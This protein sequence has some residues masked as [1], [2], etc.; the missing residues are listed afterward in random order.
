MSTTRLAE[1]ISLTRAPSS[2]FRIAIIGGVAGGAS[3]AAKARRVSELHE[4]TVFESG[5]YVS[6]ANCGLP[7]LA[8]STQ[9]DVTALLLSDP[10]R[11]R[12]RFNVEVKVNHRVIKIDRERRILHVASG[13]ADTVQHPYDRLIIATGAGAIMP[14][15]AVLPT[16]SPHNNVWAVKSIHDAQHIKE[17]T[18]S[19]KRCVIVGAGFV[20]VEMAEQLMHAGLHVTMLEMATH[21][22][23]P[24]DEDIACGTCGVGRRGHRPVLTRAAGFLTEMSDVIATS[25]VDLRLG[26]K[27]AGFVLNEAGDRVTA[28][29]IDG[30]Q[31]PLETDMVIL[32]LGV[33]SMSQLARDCGLQVGASGGIVVD[34]RMQT[35]D[36]F[37]YA[38]GDVCETTHLVSGHKMVTALAG[39]ANKQGRVAGA[40]AAGE[41][42][43]YRGSLG[44]AIVQF[45]KHA[46]ALTGLN[47]AKARELGL[48]YV[49]LLLH[50]SDHA[51]YYPGASY[52]L[53]KMLV[54]R[55]TG[56]ILGAQAF[57]QAGVDKRIDVIATA[58]QGNLSAEE[59][60]DLDL[61]YAPQFSQARDPVLMLGLQYQDAVR[62]ERFLSASELLA[63]FES[64]HVSQVID[65]RSPSEYAAGHLAGAINVPLD[66]MRHYVHEAA[67][68]ADVAVYCRS[69]FRS[70]LATRILASAASV[71]AFNVSGGW[72]SIRRAQQQQQRQP[73]QANNK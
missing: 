14:A 49:P 35:S 20:G 43:T 69:G 10:E 33:R 9:P 13:G 61:C 19:A 50:G 34:E 1:E 5:A 53:L 66:S 72:L 15:W 4:I 67:I 47:E 52:T 54:E 41:S 62:G 21:V 11:F 3:A 8:G 40:N 36:P 18:R 25:G 38:A 22:L 58:I 60:G 28:V 51:S 26:R 59:L 56:K 63:Q 48:N 39:P 68:P 70:Y 73:D 64:G 32:S 31:A 27:C 55:T 2:A 7:Y 24:L 30:E 23:P 44:T 42:L 29:R 45:G 37:I 71:N 65:V 46:C 16:P 6:Y 17:A 12:A 57:G